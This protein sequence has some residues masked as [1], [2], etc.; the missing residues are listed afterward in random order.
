MLKKLQVVAVLLCMV[1]YASA[2][3]ASIGTA[4]ARG[5]VRVDSYVV[6][7]NATLFDGT[8]VE[9]GQATADLR[10]NK[11]TQITMATGSRGT[12]YRDRLVLQ[13]G[14]S[15]LNASNSFQLEANGL[16]VIPNQP[17]SVGVVSLKAGNTVEVA[18]L[19]G[20]FG[21]TNDHGILVASVP[22]GRVASFAMKAGGNMQAAEPPAEYYGV[23]TVSYGNG[24][25]F[26]TDSTGEKFEITCKNY[27]KY[28]GKEISVKGFIQ[29]ATSPIEGVTSLVCGRTVALSSAAGMSTGSEILF[30]G[31]IAF[32]AVGFGVVIRD[33]NQSSSPASR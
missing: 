9:T 6:K 27:R 31:V 30:S 33:A 26:L 19:N 5:D 3:T 20:S 15:M 29:A 25:Y 21:V 1:L 16:H 18:A 28:V 4:S 10:L 12:L 17:S 23:G 32:T 13:Q 8:V 22:A 2:E 7:G 14:Q 24:H 11:G